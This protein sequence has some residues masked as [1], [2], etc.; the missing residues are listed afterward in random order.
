MDRSAIA[1]SLLMFG[2]LIILRL[3]YLCYLSFPQLPEVYA[4]SRLHATLC[5]LGLPEWLTEFPLS[6]LTGV[7]ARGLSVAII[8]LSLAF[9]CSFSRRFA[10][11]LSN[12]GTFAR[13][14][15]PVGQQLYPIWIRLDVVVINY[16][17]IKVIFEPFLSITINDV[18]VLFFLFLPVIIFLAF[19]FTHALFAALWLD[20]LLPVLAVSSTYAILKAFF[21]GISHFTQRYLG[22]KSDHFLARPVRGSILLSRLAFLAV[23]VDAALQWRVELILSVAYAVPI[24][25]F[26]LNDILRTLLPVDP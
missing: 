3:L 17:C 20:I 10:Q 1:S 21:A 5:Y 8:I 18:W 15:R 11:S 25:L 14:L 19:L 26:M 23:L 2:R 16:V 7:E 6:D 13:Y 4:S 9:I 24:V 22:E 12:A